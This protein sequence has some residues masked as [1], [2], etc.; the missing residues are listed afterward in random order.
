MISYIGWS[1]WLVLQRAPKLQRAIWGTRQLSVPHW[2]T[3]VE[4]CFSSA[5]VSSVLQTALYS[6]GSVPWSPLLPCHWPS[7]ASPLCSNQPSLVCPKALYQ[8]VHQALSS[9]FLAVLGPSINLAYSFVSS[10]SST[11][12]SNCF[13]PPPHTDT[14]VFQDDQ[15][16]K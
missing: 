10:L 4:V 8:S 11:L 14:C 1:M 15:K 2:G 5:T 12:K 3:P 9:A 6:S 13:N 16:N 7:L